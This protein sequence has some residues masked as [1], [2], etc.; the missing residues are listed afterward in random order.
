MKPNTLDDQI[1]VEEF[2]PKYPPDLIIQ[3]G[4]LDMDNMGYQTDYNAGKIA[5]LEAYETLDYDGK[6]VVAFGM[7][8]VGIVPLG[9]N[10]DY[11][12]G[13]AVG[14]LEGAKLAN[15]AVL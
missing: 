11:S 12:K 8:P 7:I 5:G 6:A 9:K 2:D 10:A 3:E 1:G 14:V 13:F 4:A 15:K